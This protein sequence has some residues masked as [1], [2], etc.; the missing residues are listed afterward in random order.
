MVFGRR[1]ALVMATALLALAS[2]DVSASPPGDLKPT[3]RAQRLS[4][5]IL[6]GQR[7]RALERVRV[8]VTAADATRRKNVRAS[9]VGSFTASFPSLLVVDKCNADLSAFAVGH[10]GSRAAFKL[11]RPLCAP[12]P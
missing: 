2:G 8:T 3:L 4:P 1:F 5:L 12:Q 11:P 7:F 6:R 9:R 10:R